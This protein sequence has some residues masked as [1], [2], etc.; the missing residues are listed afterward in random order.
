M[1][2]A[3]TIEVG[4]ARLH[5]REAGEGDPLLLVHG[6]GPDSR[7]WRGAFDDLARDHRVIAYD[8]RGY[9][10]SGGAPLGGGWQRH[11]EDAIELLLR[12]DAHP[13]KVA[14]W[15][16][17][18]IVGVHL[19]VERPE[20][21][22]SLVLAE[23]GI[24]RPPVAPPS[25]LATLL[26]AKIERR[27]RG[28]RAALATL[29]RWI[30]AENGTSTWDRPEYPDDRKEELYGNAPGIW[31]D[32]AVRGRPDLSSKRLGR[33]SCPV[34]F[35]LGETSQPW[36]GRSGEVFL[37]ATPDADLVV[38]EGTNHAFTFHQPERFAEAIRAA[39]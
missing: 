22:S 23:T 5:Y 17:G 32:F 20:L 16:G 13:A 2:G 11:G 6:S 24:A 7:G 9:G 26:R 25:F 27:L 28:D 33:I 12:L 19:A 36:F 21:V 8:R 30:M 34:T 39:R 31:A 37:E 3:D 4:G 18:G 35:V 29:L 14:G 38:I 10:G 15:S 1:E